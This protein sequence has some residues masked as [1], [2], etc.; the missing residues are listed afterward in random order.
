MTKTCLLITVYLH[1]PFILITGRMCISSL[2]FVVSVSLF[3]TD[4][5]SGSSH[6]STTA[7]VRTSPHGATS[8]VKALLSFRPL[9]V[10]NYLAHCFLEAHSVLSVLSA[11]CRSSR[12]V[13][14]WVFPHQQPGA[15]VHQLRQWE[16]AAAL[17]GSLPPSSAGSLISFP[18]LRRAVGSLTV[19]CLLCW[20]RGLR[21]AGGAFSLRL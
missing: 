4:C 6:S 7:Y 1:K 14:L 17:C 13:R 15:A 20:C 12:C 3:P 8:S 16:T 5:S 19:I 11:I 18:D 21:V 9:S 2:S 10:W